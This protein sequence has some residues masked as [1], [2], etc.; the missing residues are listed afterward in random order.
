M[1]LS[2]FFPQWE[3]T[4]ATIEAWHEMLEDLEFDLARRAL[5][6]VLSR[7]SGFPRVADIRRAAAEIA[8]GPEGALTGAEAWEMVRAAVRRYGYYRELEA[9][10]SLPAPVARA[11]DALGWEE[12][13]LSEEPGVVRA[14]F[15][16]IFEQLQERR[17]EET[18]M[19]AEVKALLSGVGQALPAGQAEGGGVA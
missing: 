17:R 18:V 3:L 11:V 7:S 4:E 10:A 13:C 19:P 1:F 6:A 8:A 15:I 14:Q 16:R 5:K 2:A 12:I 9:K